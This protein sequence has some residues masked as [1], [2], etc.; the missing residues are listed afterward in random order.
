M[1]R[2]L[3]A[4]IALVLTATA[5]AAQQAQPDASAWLRSGPMLGYSEM[6]ETVVWLQ[7]R[8]PARA[9]LRFWKQGRPETA[10]LSEPVQTSEAGDLI[11]RFTLSGLEFGT[12]YDYEVYL[13]GLRVAR[14]YAMTFQTQPMWRYR[15]DPPTL[16][17]A[18]GSC[19]YINDP[20]YDRP[21][22][23]YGEG[24]DIFTAIAAQKPDLMLWL[25]DNV[26]YREAD[27][28][29]E[30]A[31]RYRYAHT[32]E[33]PELQPLLAS[34]HQYATWD[35]HDYGP[36]NSDRTF[37]LRAAALRVFKDYWA[38]PAY[39]TEETPGV[40]GRFEWGDVEFFLLDDRYHRSPND[41][42]NGPDKV[43]F[44]EAQLRWLMESLR[45]SRA[46]FKIV[47]GGNQMLNPLTFYEAFGNF[48]DEQKRL[49]AFLRDA[50]IN[51]VLFLSG[52]R[53]H[54]ELIKIEEPGMYPLYDFTSS[55]LT[56]GGSRNE[57]E[58]NNPA[59]VPGTW[60][61]DGV[62]NFGLLEVSGP[63]KDRKLILR[64]L[65]RAG[66]ELWRHEIKASE[67]RFPQN[68]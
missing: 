2:P 25:G 7:T 54:T 65:D 1:K 42:P 8:K 45:S 63:E 29:S 64:T 26:Y 67:L 37:R 21:G 55:P 4:L 47:V 27:W 44:G 24:Y 6:T 13:D 23:P 16:R 61:T 12:K 11:A 31:M 9:Q 66:K 5:I 40:F 19:S 58:A 38:N 28:L 50:R 43:M 33:L 41:M 59:R 32:R 30:S 17:V 53:H 57:R 10:R 22:K 39:G 56:S 3:S 35:D 60:V 48:P 14:P 15:A 18:M 34:A 52:D 51:G 36:N 68:G 46:T 49:L 20:P 62:K